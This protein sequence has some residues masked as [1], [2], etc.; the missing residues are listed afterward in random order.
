MRSPVLI[1]TLCQYV[2]CDMSTIKSPIATTDK[3]KSNQ[4]DNN[5]ILINTIEYMLM[6]PKIYDNIDI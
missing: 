5:L 2:A 3:N 4:C 1:K 6:Q